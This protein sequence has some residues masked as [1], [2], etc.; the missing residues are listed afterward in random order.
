MSETL[1]LSQCLSQ[2]NNGATTSKDPALS[3]T[4]SRTSSNLSPPC[5]SPP[6]L[7]V[8][9]GVLAALLLPLR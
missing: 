3:N 9:L 2:A 5:A 1:F 6:L 8:A 7:C 4:T